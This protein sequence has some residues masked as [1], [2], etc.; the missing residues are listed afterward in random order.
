MHQV[1]PKGRDGR[2]S[3]VGD[4]VGQER[5][6]WERRY[7]AGKAW[8]MGEA[9]WKDY[10]VKMGSEQ[11]ALSMWGQILSAGVSE[12]KVFVLQC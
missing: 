10:Y 7:G 3:G 6:R 8:R 1:A 4:G 2:G 11:D 5:E 9:R 12:R